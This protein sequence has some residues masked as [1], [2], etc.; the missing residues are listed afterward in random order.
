MALKERRRRRR[1]RLAV[2]YS[3]YHSSTTGPERVGFRR[4]CVCVGWERVTH[5]R[6]RWL[7]VQ[8]FKSGAAAAA[9]VVALMMA[10][11]GKRDDDDDGALESVTRYGLRW[12]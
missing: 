5:S 3:R 12:W 9:A 4:L 2:P 8:G 10:N 7:L 11:D 6:N 1:V